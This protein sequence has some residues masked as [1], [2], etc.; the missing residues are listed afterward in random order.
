[1]GKDRKDGYT[2]M[3]MNRNLQISELRR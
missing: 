3:K 1:V 2:A